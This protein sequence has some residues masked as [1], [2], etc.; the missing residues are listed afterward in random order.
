MIPDDGPLH[1]VPG[2]RP[3]ADDIT[4]RPVVPVPVRLVDPDDHD[5]R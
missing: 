1:P 3:V 4:V 2:D 5:R